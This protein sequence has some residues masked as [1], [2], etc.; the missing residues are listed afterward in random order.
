MIGLGNMLKE[1]RINNGVS[2]KEASEDLNLREVILQNIEEGNIGAFKDVHKLRD[3]ISSYA[4]YL[5]LDSSEVI[6]EFNEYLFEYTSKIPLKEIEK[7]VMEMNHKNDE[8]IKVNSPYSK[9]MKK[10][11]Q[12]YYYII[13]AIIVVFIILVVLWS[14]RQITVKNNETTVVSYVNR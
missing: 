7:K 13:Y 9:P 14:I 5:G 1:A 4:K 6:D 3:D 12:K 10:Y 11:P 2:M 8:E